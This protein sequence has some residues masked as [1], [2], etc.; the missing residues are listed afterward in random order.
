M[1]KPFSPTFTK[2]DTS[3][4]DKELSSKLDSRKNQS[5]NR[6]M[7]CGPKISILEEYNFRLTSEGN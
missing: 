4:L 7:R 5:S 6:H 2:F 3:V 1:T